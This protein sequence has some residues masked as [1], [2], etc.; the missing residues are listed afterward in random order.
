[1]VCGV[2]SAGYVYPG[3]GASR[4]GGTLTTRVT[5]DQRKALVRLSPC[6]PDGTY[7]VGGVAVAAFLDHRTSHDLDLFVANTD[8]SDLPDKVVS[9][10][11]TVLTSRGDGVVH[12]TLDGIPTTILRY[13]YPLLEPTQSVSG[14]PVPVASPMDLAAMKLS[15]ITSRGAKRDFWD[16]HVL[17]STGN[18]P[19]LEDTLEAF[20][21]KYE[22]EDIGHVVKSLVYFGDAELEPF[23]AGLNSTLWQTIKADLVDWVT[24]L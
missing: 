17:L 13:D 20:S 6:L 1:M 16:L 10:P 7:L 22:A 15:A 23:P 9:L 24:A 14:L 2:S 4:V 3:R 21:R 18:A 5:P 12:L 11:E 8:L 19:S